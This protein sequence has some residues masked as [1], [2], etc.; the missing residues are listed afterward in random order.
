MSV[1]KLLI[2]RNRIYGGIYNC[3]ESTEIFEL[4][5]EIF[6]VQAKNSK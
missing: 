5:N 2:G 3:D 1:Q 4:L 6:H